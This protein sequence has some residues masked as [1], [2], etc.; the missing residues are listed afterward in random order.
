MHAFNGIAVAGVPLAGLAAS[1]M[2]SIS[3]P[4]WRNLLTKE[5]QAPY[6]AKVCTVQSAVGHGLMQYLINLLA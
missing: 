6:F 1:L 5:F 4:T 2:G 3:C